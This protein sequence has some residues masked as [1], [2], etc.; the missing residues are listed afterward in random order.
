MTS[1]HPFKC[2]FCDIDATI[3]MEDQPNGKALPF[4]TDGT[5]HKHVKHSKQQQQ[6]Q[7]TFRPTPVSDTS[8]IMNEQ[9]NQ[10]KNP[11]SF[12]QRAEAIAMAHKENMEA[13]ENLTNAVKD[14]NSNISKLVD[15]VGRYL[16]RS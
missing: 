8:A 15:L 2:Q 12:V 3:H 6:Y 13:S 14:L 9:E 10:N 1:S 4:N 11:A 5:P 16:D 7:Q